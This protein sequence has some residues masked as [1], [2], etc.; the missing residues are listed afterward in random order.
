MTSYP[1]TVTFIVTRT[2]DLTET[3]FS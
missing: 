1:S 2:K 3:C